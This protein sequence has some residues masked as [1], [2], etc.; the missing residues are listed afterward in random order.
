MSA[1]SRVAVR[2]E[3]LTKAFGSVVAL[4]HVTVDVMAGEAF[5]FLGPNGAGK[6]T[7]IRLLLGLARP[8]SGRMAVMGHDVVNDRAAALSDMAY[9]PGE[10]TCW[11]SLRGSEMLDL[12][13]AVRGSPSPAR[14]AELTDRFN[15]DPTRLGREYS[16]GNRQKI[17]LISAFAADASVLV[18]DEPTSG[19]DPLME[20]EF[21]GCV[22][23][24]RER[25]QTIFLSSHILSEVE[26][27]CDRVGILREGSLVDVGT[28]DAMRELRTRAVSVRFA[29]P[30]PRALS[31]VAGVVGYEVHGQEARFQLAGPPGPLLDALAGKVVLSLDIQEPSLE[32]LFL[33]FYGDHAVSA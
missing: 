31:A 32:E 9:V 10:F 11:P 12:L 20:M 22:A 15:F 2:T 29:G 26:A 27:V 17:P 14:V 1:T 19:L 8:T 25:G 30:A 3:A 7:F 21:R 5:G 28:L 4:N 24:A 18:L 16:K 13:G 33:T 23:E 6:T